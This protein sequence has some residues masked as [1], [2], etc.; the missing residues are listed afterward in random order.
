MF[1]Q[2]LRKNRFP[3]HRLT[4]GRGV[5]G[6]GSTRWKIGPWAAD[7]E[8]KCFN[9]HINC[10]Q[11]DFIAVLPVLLHPTERCSHKEN[12]LLVARTFFPPFPLP[13]LTV[14]CLR[15]SQAL[16]LHP[17]VL[18]SWLWGC[19]EAQALP[20]TLCLGISDSTACTSPARPCPSLVPVGL[21]GARG[22]RLSR[23]AATTLPH[24]PWAAAAGLCP[25]WGQHGPACPAVPLVSRLSCPCGAAPSCC[26]PPD[27]VEPVCPPRSVFT[28]VNLDLI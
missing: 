8:Q 14:T 19:I 12:I 11:A 2:L 9:H 1:F 3:E 13:D 6:A 16:A 26:S 7:P 22:L 25:W 17:W 5:P 10:V 24:S 15:T 23:I 21:P 27:F 4:F 28:E 20:Y 18:T